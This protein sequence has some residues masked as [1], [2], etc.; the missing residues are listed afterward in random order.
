MVY[1]ASQLIHF[2]AAFFASG[3]ARAL[4]GSI[5]TRALIYTLD[6]FGGR[7]GGDEEAS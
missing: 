4:T 2:I 1:R 3:V 6:R 5:F 7:G